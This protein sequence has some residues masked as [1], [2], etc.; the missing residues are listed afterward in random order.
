MIRKIGIVILVKAAE[1]IQFIAIVYSEAQESPSPSATGFAQ[2]RMVEDCQ[3][4]A[5]EIYT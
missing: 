5:E 3:S 4:H 2:A 1:Y